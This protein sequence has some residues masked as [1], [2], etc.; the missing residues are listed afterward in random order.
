[1]DF[2]RKK[3]E[4]ASNVSFTNLSNG[5]VLVY[6]SVTEKWENELVGGTV[7]I[8]VANYSALPTPAAGNGKFYW[9]QS[10]QGTKWLP[11]SLGG[12]Y[13]PAGLYHSN[14]TT[15]E[16]MN[17]PYQATQIEVDAGLDSEKFVTSSTLNG[18]SKWATKA[19]LASPTFTGNPEAPTAT[20]LDNSTKIA[21]TAYVDAAVS[22]SSGGTMPT[23][24]AG[25]TSFNFGNEEDS[26]VSTIADLTITS[27]T[28]I[29]ALFFPQETSAT[30]LDDF[31]LNGVSFSLENIVDNTSFDIRATAANNASGTYTIKY[32]LQII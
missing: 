29:S 28:V 6:N 23:V 15:W 20:P 8:V 12:T 4:K 11:G 18:Y 21:T 24:V 17:T 1:M 22:A 32:I 27:T 9:C 30:S 13:Y 7:T 14:G 31:K 3:L 2:R 26:V 16:F 25:L 10:S 19:D 5:D